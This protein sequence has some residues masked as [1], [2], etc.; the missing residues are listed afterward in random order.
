MQLRDL[1][2]EQNFDPSSAPLYQLGDAVERYL[3][4]PGDLLFRSRGERNTA[5]VIAPQSTTAAVAVLPLIVLRPN[6]DL[7]DPHYLA[8]AIN[9]TA[10]QR[11]FDK[12]AVGTSMRMIP[13]AALD[14]LEVELPDLGTQKL[15]S[16]LDALA[17]RE[18]E[19]AHELADKKFEMMSLAL[20]HQAQRIPTQ[21]HT[22][23]LDH[24]D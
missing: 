10:T 9:Q 24:H 18:R 21:G 3:A 20:L 11:Y 8:W 1:E 23:P 19:L 5:V 12:Y 17:R 16:E 4:T 13:K 7:V 6:R 14:G 15:I 2:D 22:V